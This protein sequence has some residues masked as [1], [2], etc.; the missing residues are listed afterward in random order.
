MGLCAWLIRTLLAEHV[1]TGRTQTGE[2]A[3]RA[4][5]GSTRWWKKSARASIFP[6]TRTNGH[7]HLQLPGFVPH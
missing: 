4:A 6:L 7:A 1:L 5:A 3:L 2:P